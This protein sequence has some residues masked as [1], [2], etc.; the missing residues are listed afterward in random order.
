MQVGSRDV[1]FDLS[2]CLKPT[3]RPVFAAKEVSWVV[4]LLERAGE[5]LFTFFHAFAFL[6][7]WL[8]T[9][10]LVIAVVVLAAFPL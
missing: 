7:S 4:S 10:A 8:P 9:L 2:D 3:G 6:H 5:A 1:L